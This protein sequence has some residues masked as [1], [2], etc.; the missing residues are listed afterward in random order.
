MVKAAR[1]TRH[2][3]HSKNEGLEGF[4]WQRGC[5]TSNSAWDKQGLKSMFYRKNLFISI[6][7]HFHLCISKLSLLFFTALTMPTNTSNITSWRTPVVKQFSRFLAN[8]IS[9]EPELL[10][11]SM[12][13][14]CHLT[15]IHSAQ[16]QH[17]STIQAHVIQDW[18]KQRNAMNHFWNT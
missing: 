4:W 5:V 12:R 14:W 16:T 2:S 17:Y 13:S 11:T 3:K 6:S 1:C 9:H 8:I 7:F 18:M 10:R 15:S